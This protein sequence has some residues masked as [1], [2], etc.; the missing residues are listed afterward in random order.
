MFEDIVHL[1]PM[2]ILAGLMAGWVAEAV[3][4][5]G[6]Y[7]L[8]PD[9]ALSLVGS[10]LAGTAVWVAV[11]GD[12]AMLAMFWIGCGGAALVVVAQRRLWRHGVA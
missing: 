11:S 3:A 1:G 12:A 6:G 4:H 8:I 2:L 10:A 9:I 5:A 7:G